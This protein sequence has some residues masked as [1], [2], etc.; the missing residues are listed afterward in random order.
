MTAPAPGIEPVIQLPKADL[1]LM[2]GTHLRQKP[3]TLPGTRQQRP[4]SSILYNTRGISPAALLKNMDLD[5]RDFYGMKSIDVVGLLYG[6]KKIISTGM[7][8]SQVAGLKKAFGKHGLLCKAMD[9]GLDYRKQ[10][11]TY[12]IAKKAS[13]IKE[14]VAAYRSN[15]YDLIGR[16]LG[17]PECCVRHHYRLVNVKDSADDFVRRCHANSA[18][19]F[20]PINN[21]LD[22]DGRICG[23]KAA[24]MDFSGVQH[25]SLISHNPCAYDC[26]PSLKLAE[27]NRD[28]LRKNILRP[29][30]ESDYS[31]LAKPVLYADDYNLAIL[32]GTSDPAGVNYSGTAYILGFD[33]ARGKI[34]SGDRVAVSGRVFCVLRG[35]KSIFRQTLPKKPLILPF[36]RRAAALSAFPEK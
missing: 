14:A 31:I 1:R 8:A 11:P 18:G 16:L 32:N 22:F 13:H 12:V 6:Y 29:G 36:D 26:R 28:N 33:D 7:A 20:W 15:R 19:F 5:L 35:G 27:L 30:A 9:I 17:Y 3:I 2:P 21:V 4:L 10:N 34:A 24:G 23:R 25:A